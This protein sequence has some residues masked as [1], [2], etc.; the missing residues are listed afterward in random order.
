MFHMKQLIYKHSSII[1]NFQTPNVS[2]ETSPIKNKSNNTTKQTYSIKNI[3]NTVFI[4]Y[5]TYI[6]LIKNN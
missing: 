1:T 2:R 3:S 5:E 4:S 6:T